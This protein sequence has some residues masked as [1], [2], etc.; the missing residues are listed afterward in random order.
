L[1]LQQSLLSDKNRKTLVLMEEIEEKK[2]LKDPKLKQIEDFYMKSDNHLETFT[3]MKTSAK[4]EFLENSFSVLRDFKIALSQTIK[5][6]K[7][8]KY[9]QKAI[10]TLNYQENFQIIVKYTAEIL[11]CEKVIPIWRK[12]CICFQYFLKQFFNKYFTPFFW[13]GF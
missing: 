12:L 9:F 7:V 1:A 2:V 13:G 8:I 10:K 3:T 11:D 5:M 6:K 4:K